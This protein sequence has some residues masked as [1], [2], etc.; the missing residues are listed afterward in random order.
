ML[1]FYSWLAADGSLE[2]FAADLIGGGALSVV[3]ALVAS[4]ALFYFINQIEG[5]V[6]FVPLLAGLILLYVLGKEAHLSPLIIVLVC[7]LVFN[8]P[9]LLTWHGRLRRIRTDGYAH[10]LHE[11]KSLVAEL[12][13]AT[14]SI[15]FLLLGYWTDVRSMLSVTALL[16]AIAGVAGILAARYVVLTLLRRR[17][18]ASLVWLAPRGLVTV[19]LFLSAQ[20]AG[21]VDGFPFGAVMLVVLITS[22]LTALAHRGVRPE[23]RAQAAADR[24]PPPRTRRRRSTRT[25]RFLLGHAAD[26]DAFAPAR[27]CGLP[28]SPEPSMSHV[29]DPREI[30][31][32]R[33]LAAARR[34]LDDLLRGEPLDP[35]GTPR[36]RAREPHR[37]LRSAPR[38][39]RPRAHE[40]SARRRLARAGA[41]SR[42]RR[43][44]EAASETSHTGMDGWPIGA[45]PRRRSPCSHHKRFWRRT[46]SRSIRN[47]RCR[48]WDLCRRR[49]RGDGLPGDGRIH[50]R[51]AECAARLQHARM[52][53]G[54]VAAA[55]AHRAGRSHHA[56]HG[57]VT[58]SDAPR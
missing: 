56:W 3:A 16:V 26:G 50:V 58:R 30:A 20:H 37:G 15:F 53:A 31:D 48:S 32:D 38:G 2:I 49:C 14:K 17:D 57:R 7:G 8:N 33:A 10:T 29:L 44:A 6:R 47:F 28:T 55:A 35:A 11:F 39:I 36:Q 24:S 18:A 46:M 45:A 12:T 41:E 27:R 54:R 13:F 23:D 42:R 51:P 4:I 1:V 40:A 21:K 34:E 19:L 25:S 22:A 43:C 5:H 9:Q 52:A